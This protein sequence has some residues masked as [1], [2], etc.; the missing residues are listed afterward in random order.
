MGNRFSERAQS[1]LSGIQS[2][3]V[4]YSGTR[5]R[6]ISEV[7]PGIIWQIYEVLKEDVT[8]QGIEFYMRTSYPS[9][10]QN[11]VISGLLS[12]AIHEAER[13]YLWSQHLQPHTISPQVFKRRN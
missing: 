3:L 7:P 8:P 10:Y 5:K 9:D 4:A 13:E 12:S 2:W 11:P 6:Q 1:R